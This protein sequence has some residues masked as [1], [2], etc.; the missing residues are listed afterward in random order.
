MLF[1]FAGRNIISKIERTQQHIKRRKKKEKRKKEEEEEE[2]EER[3]GKREEVT[4]E[5]VTGYTKMCSP[6]D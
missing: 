6:K 5:R 4:K 2:E 1:K 3:R